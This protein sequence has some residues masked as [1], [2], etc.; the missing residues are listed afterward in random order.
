[1][2]KSEIQSQISQINSNKIVLEL[3]TGLGKTLS[4]ILLLE[5]FGGFWHI[6]IA[7]RTH[8]QNWIDEFK[9]HG[10]EHLLKNVEIFCHASLHKHTHMENL[11]VDEVHRV[12][13]DA[14]LNLIRKSN[15]N[16]F[17]G[18]S[19]TIT[20]FQHD[21]LRYAIG[22]YDIVKITLS[23]AID[24]KVLPEP[25]VY[26]IGV[27]LGNINRDH[28]YSFGT[29]SIKVTEQEWYNK[30]S[31]YIESAKSRFMTTREEYLK[32]RWL[33]AANKRKKFLSDVKTKYARIL[34]RKLENKRLICFC[35]SI[36]QSETLGHNYAIHSNNKEEEN[37]DRLDNFNKLLTNKIFAVG[38]LKEGVNLVDIEAGV[39]VQLD[40]QVRYYTQVLGRSLR[41]LSPELYILYVKDTQDYNYTQNVLEGFNMDYVKFI[42]LE[43]V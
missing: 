29:K 12:F 17:I 22:N 43:E 36:A 34:L 1:M 5:K 6:A 20:K 7:E 41:S 3:A 4:A 24:N 31:S 37:Q 27:S 39:I 26:F 42:N 30:Q 16:R 14:R 33:Q 18:L 8:K 13:T 40:N 35:G 2:D 19:A 9:K 15:P 21:K 10:K 23:E 11:I 28:N 38:K 32:N 25:M